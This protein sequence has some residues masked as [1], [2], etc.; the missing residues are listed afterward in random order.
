MFQA[1]GTQP[2]QTYINRRQKKLAEWVTTHPIFEVCAP[3]KGYEGG[4][5]GEA[6]SAVVKADGSRCP[7][8]GHI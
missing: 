8:E 4:G 6:K 1:V 5:R 2:L 7:S 3:D